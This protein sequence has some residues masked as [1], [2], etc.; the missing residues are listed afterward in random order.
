MKRDVDDG[1]IHVPMSVHWPAAI[2]KAR[3]DETPW[4]RSIVGEIHREFVQLFAEH[5]D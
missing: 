5:A 2:T 3:V 1:G 4:A